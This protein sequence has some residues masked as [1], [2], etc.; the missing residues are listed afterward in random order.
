VI[1]NLGDY[2]MVRRWH[3]SLGIPD[4]IFL[5]GDEA[6]TECMRRFFVMP[7]LVLAAKV[8]PKDTEATLFAMLMAFSNF[9]SSIGQFLGSTLLEFLGVV[10]CY[11]D[12]ALEAPR[13]LS[14]EEYVKKGCGNLDKAILV[15]ALCRALPLLIIPILVPDGTPDGPADDDP[16]ACERSSEEDDT[17][18]EMD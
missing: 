13:A 5:L 2:V 14:E 3:L 4:H 12:M 11:A 18:S 9:G 6:F 16:N 17:S 10:D 1:S 8:C 7:M 15:K